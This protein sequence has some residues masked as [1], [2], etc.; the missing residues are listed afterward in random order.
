MTLLPFSRA[1]AAQD[2]ECMQRKRLPLDE[3]DSRSWQLATALLLYVPYYGL[4]LAHARRRGISMP[5]LLVVAIVSATPM[6]IHGYRIIFSR[7]RL[8]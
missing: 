1:K 6:L 4:V 2:V 7:T 8:F 5:T 3:I